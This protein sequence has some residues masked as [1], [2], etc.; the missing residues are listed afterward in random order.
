[1]IEQNQ[2]PSLT[3]D[4]KVIYFHNFPDTDP[5]FKRIPWDM[6]L[7][8]LFISQ[9]KVLHRNIFKFLAWPKKIKHAQNELNAIRYNTK[10]LLKA[11]LFQQNTHFFNLPRQNICTIKTKKYSNM[12]NSIS[13]KLTFNHSGI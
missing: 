4:R 2:A 1:M 5:D 3:Y 10:N 13:L 11:S 7:Y 12:L 8:I 6:Y 9:H